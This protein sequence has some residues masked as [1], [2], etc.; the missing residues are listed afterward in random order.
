MNDAYAARRPG[1]PRD[2]RRT[3][4][5]IGVLAIVTAAGTGFYRSVEANVDATNRLLDADDRAA[6]A[7]FEKQREC[8]GRRLD[9]L[10]P[11]GAAVRVDVAPPA[12]HRI[13]EAL[14]PDHRIVE[15]DARQQGAWY[16]QT[17][18]QGPKTGCLRGLV[19]TAP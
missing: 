18:R 6:Q 9:A 5:L 13:I 16:I 15:G 12:A 17:S 10:I 1:R 8:L 4:V 11:D 14:L 19:V 3:V 7:G 2:S